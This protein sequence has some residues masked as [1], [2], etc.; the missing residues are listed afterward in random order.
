[1]RIEAVCLAMA[2]VF[3][4]GQLVVSAQSDIQSK[5]GT[6]SYRTSDRG[7]RIP[8]SSFAGYRASEESIPF[9]PVR[10]VVGSPDVDNTMAIQDAIDQIAKL[11]LDQHG[12]RGAVLIPPGKYPVS[13][14]LK[15]RASGV[16]VRGCGYSAANGLQNRAD[17]SATDVTD[18]HTVVVATGTSRRSVFEV[19]GNPVD[20]EGKSTEIVDAY[21]P[22]NSTKLTV[23]DATGIEK[24]QLVR[25]SHPSSEAWI[26]HL[27]MNDFGGDRHGPRW[28][29]GSRDLHWLREVIQV[30]GKT[31]TLDA[32][33]TY[34]LD[35]SLSVCSVSKVNVDSLVRNVGIE[36]L[37]I[38]STYQDTNPKDEEHAWFGVSMNHVRDAW[39]RRVTCVNLAGS[40]VAVWEGASRVT[41]EDCKSLHPVSELGGWRRNSFFACGQQILMQRLYAEDGRHDFAIGA[42][43]AGPNAFVQCEAVRP[44]GESGTIDSAACGTLLDRVRC[45][46]QSLALRNR[47]YQSQGAGWTSLN[48]AMWNCTASV[49]CVERPPTAQNWAF[50]SHGEYSGNGAWFNSDDNIQPES[51][52][53]AQLAERIGNDRVGSR[54]LLQLPKIQGSRAPTIEA[55]A[56]AV[57]ASKSPRLTMSQWIDQCCAEHPLQI[58]YEGKRRVFVEVP[59]KVQAK[60]PPTGAKDG[61]DAGKDRRFSIRNGWMTFDNRLAV[62]QE[63]GVP[64][65]NGGIRPTDVAQAK[66]ALTRFVPGQDGRGYTD[67]IED[68][69][70]EMSQSGQVSLWQHP[71]LWYERRR[72]DH[73]RVQRMDGD[74]VAPFY[75]TPWARSGLGVAADGLSR[76]DLT[77]S[78]PWYFDRLRSFARIGSTHGLYL[79]NG[80]YMQHS[81]LE[82]GAHYVDAPWRPTNNVNPVGIPEPVLFAGDKLIYVAEQFYDTKNEPL[83]ELHRHYMKNVLEELGSEPNVIL[84]LSEEFTGPASFVEL[85]LEVIR[86]WSSRVGVKPRVALYA[87]KDVT[88]EILSKPHFNEVVSIVYNRFGTEGWW[89]QPDGTLYAPQGGKNLAPRQW[90]RQLKPKTPGFEQVHKTVLEYRTRYPDKPF[91]YQ[92]PAQHCWANLLGGGSLVPLPQ[93]TDQELLSAIV[94]MRPMADRIG[95]SDDRGN[96]LVYTSE[97]PKTT[98]KIRWVDTKSGQVTSG[99]P[100]S[101]ESPSLYWI[102]R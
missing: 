70:R 77:K 7:D 76:W 35:R 15:I 86:Q 52:F 94:S 30:D 10:V 87:T 101:T 24:G 96:M 26:V 69:V 28:R 22:L 1:M 80:L 93:T 17:D 32:P 83:V 53:Y 2:T 31:L 8:D 36:N 33:L 4:T 55:A 91:V 85:W 39:V 84:F 64:W 99:I 16:V 51:L 92:G 25:V 46:G 58:V 27:G 72:D 50:G 57:A 81:F 59:A 34:G 38:E 23:A 49:V 63:I 100:R 66:P 29:P 62:G 12:F 6:L 18:S 88:D 74:V 9:V 44:T 60:E 45:D 14:T 56:A 47:M 19:Q 13:G 75:E 42:C 98:G 90:S 97:P 73:S 82:A 71:P 20:I 68:L 40:A 21:V 11:P 5:D 102:T 37:S 78:N 95:L 65:W 79:F 61:I 41:V 54:A 48:G 89:Y 67:N 43:A 3:L